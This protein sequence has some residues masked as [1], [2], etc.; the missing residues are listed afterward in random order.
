MHTLS[1]S[2]ELVQQQIRSHQ[3]NRATASVT[4]NVILVPASAA[5]NAS[6]A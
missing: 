3:R 1:P 2:V 4:V 6:S 5:R